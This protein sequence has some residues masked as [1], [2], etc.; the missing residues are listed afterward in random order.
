MEFRCLP[1]PFS[2]QLVQVLGV[3]CKC[4]LEPRLNELASF[5]TVR[6]KLL[7]HFINLILEAMKHV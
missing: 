7:V 6:L 4:H 1:C 5:V 2:K 3:L